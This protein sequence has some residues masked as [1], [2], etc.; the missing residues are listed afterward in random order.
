MSEVIS[1]L[2]K[3]EDNLANSLKNVE[4]NLA[5]SLKNVENNLINSEVLSDMTLRDR[6]LSIFQLG[7]GTFNVEVYD[8]NNEKVIGTKSGTRF[9]EFDI[10]TNTLT[11]KFIYNREQNR[12]ICPSSV[13]SD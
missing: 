10:T 2:E 4:I 1:A 3:V 5:N 13:L 6:L 12:R 9:C 8:D 11:A 7:A